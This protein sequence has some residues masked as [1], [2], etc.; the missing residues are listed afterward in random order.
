MSI[1]SRILSRPIAVRAAV[2][3]ACASVVA[4]AAYRWSDD[5]VEGIAHAQTAPQT[6]TDMLTGFDADAMATFV[7]D[8]TSCPA[9]PASGLSGLFKERFYFLSEIGCEN[10]P[11]FLAKVKNSVHANATL[12]VDEQCTVHQ[13]IQ[14][15]ARFTLAGV[16]PAGQGVLAF[17]D[18]PDHAPALSVESVL[19]SGVSENV[20]RDLWIVRASGGTWNTGINVSGGNIVRLENVR[21]SGFAVG[22]FG[23]SAYSVVVEGSTFYGNAFNVMI[24]RDANHWRFRDNT[25]GLATFYSVKVFGPSDG[26]GTW[27]NDHLFSGNRFEGSLVGAMMLGSYATI[28]ENNRFESNGY[29]GVY[30]TGSA[31][32]TRVH[33]N[34]F[35]TDVV[36]DQGQGTRCDLNIPNSACPDN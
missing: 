3:V 23:K 20:I 26:P 34:V 22:L 4:S 12:I 15:P 32:E 27:N 2:L 31:T 6:S 10:L 14:I 16:G 29:N 5:L 1:T 8:T 11:C 25:L 17:E 7:A 19:P 24:H 36:N 28:V 35:S 21:V 13:P 18:L 30:I 33:S 9:I